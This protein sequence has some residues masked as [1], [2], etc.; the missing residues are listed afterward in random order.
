MSSNL[1]PGVTMDD[2]LTVAYRAGYDD[3]AAGR[4]R[5]KSGAEA[6]RNIQFDAISRYEKTINAIADNMRLAAADIYLRWAAG[7][8]KALGN[9]DYSSGIMDVGDAFAAF[10]KQHGDHER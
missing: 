5:Q 8:S 2:A 1:P 7:L 10:L 3:G 9:H 4:V 6:V